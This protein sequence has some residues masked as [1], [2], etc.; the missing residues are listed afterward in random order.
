MMLRA[1]R[2]DVASSPL[3]PS[4]SSPLRC[5][6]RPLRTRP[7]SSRSSTRCSRSETSTVATDPSLGRR[8]RATAS[9]LEVSATGSLVG[10]PWA[11]STAGG[12]TRP[13]AHRNDVRCG[14]HP[15]RGRR[16]VAAFGAGYQRSSDASRSRRRSARGCGSSDS[17][18]WHR[19]AARSPPYASS[20]QGLRQASAA[21]RSGAAQD[22]PGG[23]IAWRRWTRGLS[24]S[25]CA[26]GLTSEMMWLARSRSPSSD[27]MSGE[28]A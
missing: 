25:V 6:L 9:T 13:A 22:R 1:A 14:P 18:S 8:R 26:T 17:L 2:P 4:R 10:R 11:S 20:C 3:R 5:S 19:A 23:A 21:N 16:W 27:R 15:C 7:Q 12:R 28:A 24:P